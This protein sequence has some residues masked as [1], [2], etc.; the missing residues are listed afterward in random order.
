M[1]IDDLRMKTDVNAGSLNI[2]MHQKKNKEII[3]CQ[4]TTREIAFKNVHA[5]LLSAHNITEL[6]NAK[7][8]LIQPERK[9]T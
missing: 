6:E 5:C 8:E 4:E 2:R 3:I 7:A 1:T 9:S